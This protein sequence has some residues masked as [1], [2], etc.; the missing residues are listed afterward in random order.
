MSQTVVLAPIVAALVKA[1][2]VLGKNRRWQSINTTQKR[3]LQEAFA[4][5]DQLQYFSEK[6][7]RSWADRVA[8]KLNKILKDEGFDIELEDF[9]EGEFGVVSILDV[10]V[11]WLMRGQKIELKRKNKKYPAVRLPLEWIDEAGKHT[12]TA[13][14]SSTHTHPIAL[15]HTKSGDQVYMTVAD[16]QLEG[17]ELKSR[18]DKMRVE[19]KPGRGY[20]ESLQF[21]MIDLDQRVDIGWLVGMKTTDA[22]RQDWK[23][24][25]AKQHKPNLR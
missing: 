5:R 18:I 21:P 13:H 3:F 14:E 20:Y 22:K 12:F 9:S 4:T 1:E 24:S 2:D 6:E 16:Q 8:A 25:Q 15:V 11:E 7:V 23:I 19:M 17:F 10:T